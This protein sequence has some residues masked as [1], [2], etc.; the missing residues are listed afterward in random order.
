MR[1]VVMLA[2]MM[3]MI[4]ALAAGVALAKNFSGTNGPDRI[5]GTNSADKIF[6]NGGND[7]LSGKGGRDELYAGTGRDVVRGGNG[8]DYLNVANNGDESDFNC[9]AGN[10]DVAVIDGFG[11]PASD[12]N[13][14]EEVFFAGQ[15]NNPA[16]ASVTPAGLDEAVASGLLVPAE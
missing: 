1:K 2:A 14:C 4:L 16:A 5:I 7:F 12:I 3:A 13:G 10:N 6:G 15:T 9:G 11:P 8:N